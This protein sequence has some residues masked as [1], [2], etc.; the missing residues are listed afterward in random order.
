MTIVQEKL[1]NAYTVLALENRKTIEAVPE[2]RCCLTMS[3]INHQD[4]G[5]NQSGRK[6][7]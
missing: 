6:D 7:D 2:R 5:R 1:I 3:R 4:R